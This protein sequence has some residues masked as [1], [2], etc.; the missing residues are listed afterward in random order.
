[1]SSRTPQRV[2]ELRADDRLEEARALALELHAEQPDNPTVNLQAAWTHDRMGLEEEAVPFYE[3]AIEGGLE[4]DDLRHA[5]LGLGST[6]R[7]LGHYPRSLSTLSRGV[8]L[9]PEDRG[10][11][12][13]QALALYN[14]SKSKEACALLLCLLIETTSDPDI[15]SYERSLREY[16]ADLDRIWS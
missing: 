2:A 14:N 11:Q 13:F 1:M 6:Y 9:F 10:L 3:R 16:A 12:V 8:E 15:S 5:L 4:S 7:A